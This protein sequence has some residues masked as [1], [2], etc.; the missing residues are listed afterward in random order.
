LL[1]GGIDGLTIFSPKNIHQ[2][3]Y[4]PPA[5]LVSFTQGEKPLLS[6]QTPYSLQEITLRYPDNFFEFEAA[7]LSFAQSD[8]NQYAYMLE[9]LD[10]DWIYAGA[11]RTGRYTNLPGGKYTLRVKAANHDG[12][13]N[14]QDVA[15]RITVVPPFWQTLWFRLGMLALLAGLVAMGIRAQVRS[16]KARNREL[17]RQ[18]AERTQE[19]DRRRQELEALYQADEDLYRTLHLDQVLQSLV[20]SAI[21][22]LS[23]DKGSL[24]VWDEAHQQ[25]IPRV[26]HGFQEETVERMV[27]APGEGV[28][29]TVA[30][31]GEPIIVTDT[32]QDARVTRSIIDA[33]DIRCFLQTPI[34]VGGEVF[35]VFSADYTSLR[36]IGEAEL[37]LLTSLAQ[38]AAIAIQNAQMYEQTQEQA[39]AEE[40]SRLARELH[41]AVTQTLFSASL[42]AE[43]LPAAWEN[44]PQ[45][46]RQLLSELRQL[47]R[48]A[49]AEMRTLLMELRPSVLMEANLQD[50][51]RQ[52][53]EAASGREGIPVN[54]VIDG[55]IDL[56]P[57]VHIAMYRIAQEALNNALKHAR[58]SHVTVHLRKL[59]PL[60]ASANGN[61]DGIVLTVRDDG[62][63]FDPERVP[64]DHL[65]LGIMRERAQSVGATLTVESQ[66]GHGTQIT[67][68]WE[69]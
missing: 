20:D 15:L 24:F 51:I 52:L 53:G 17:E 57:D 56:P 46:G 32:S 63:G 33:E 18:V 7:G 35:G 45:Q 9:G 14:D 10:K 44:N 2:D 43:A 27:F 39:V 48:G 60:G 5:R 66:P 62:R 30:E 68:L 31:M 34:K 69:K 55:R 23:A 54:V 41:D 11:N 16:V 1:F 64:S 29:G 19:I 42:L 21:E 28:V 38:R 22:L 47:S 12:T 67:A 37:H 59:A 40:R 4:L 50:L 36:P 65:G 25:L 13:W 49:L 61:T 58:A 8:R 6:E 26:T 3:D